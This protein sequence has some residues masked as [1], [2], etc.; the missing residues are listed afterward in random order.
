MNFLR[1]S[2]EALSLAMAYVGVLVG[3]GLSSGQDMLQYFLSFGKIGL[4]GVVL[5]GVLNVVFGR[6]IVTLGSHYQS[7]NHQEV[8][9][10]IAHPV[11]NRI[12][13]ITLIISCFVVGFVMV[14]GAC[15][16]LQQQF[17]LPSWLGALFCSL[18]VIVI[19]FLDFD[20]IT[21]V[22]GVFTPVI[23]VMILAVA[24]YTFI[25]KSYDYEALDLVAGT[26]QP[27]MPNVWLAVINYFALCAMNGVS[28]AFVL[29]GSV[30]RIGDAEKCGALGGTIIGVIVTCAAMT[31]F[32]NLDKIK[33]A[34]IPMLMIV[35]HIHPAFAFVYAV[36]IFALIFNTAFSLYYATACR[37]A[38]DDLG[39]KRKILIG[40]TAL[41]YVCSFGGFTTLV[42]YMYPL[43]GYM[44]ILL[45][46]VLTVAWF[47]ERENIV[48]EKFLRRKMMR[49]LF[50][51]YDDDYEFTA[52]HKK[53]FHK[54]GEMSAADTEGLK[55]DIKSYVKDVVEN[56]DDLQAYAKENLS[57]EG[58]P[59]KKEEKTDK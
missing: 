50:R 59:L 34:E 37:F 26:M 58:S 7:S 27:V 28:M 40:I 44:G 4:V 51:K 38:G 20:K 47:E 52:K 49:L 5:L 36:V 13:D 3:A 57:M 53:D 43:L 30:V 6:I 56:T 11:I 19:A 16:N 10:Q 35:N 42:S 32:A 8:L 14:A 21:R 39:K 33:D 25:G 1:I 18:L 12:I 45:L 29:G 24:G 22:L 2:K 9:E 46:V 31:L 15:A 41:G 55:Q 54:L 17:G 48:R 23:V